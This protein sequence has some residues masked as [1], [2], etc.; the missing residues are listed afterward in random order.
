M[1]G[2]RGRITTP[3]SDRLASHRDGRDGDKGNTTAHL[4]CR[5]R[6]LRTA[7]D[8]GGAPSRYLCPPHCVTSLIDLLQ[9]PWTVFQAVLYVGSFSDATK[10]EPWFVG[11][12]TPAAF[13]AIPV[14][15]PAPMPI[16]T[17][18]ISTIADAET[19]ANRRQ[20]RQATNTPEPPTSSATYVS[21]FTRSGDF[22]VS[23]LKR[24]VSRSITGPNGVP[25]TPYIGTHRRTSCGALRLP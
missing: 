17:L 6:Q 22:S 20:G 10:R 24:K 12:T 1:R 5:D 16:I 11:I 25:A 8:I 7:H 14:F 19:T 3:P 2:S 23:A 15:G 18:E 21:R 13:L 9:H 4:I